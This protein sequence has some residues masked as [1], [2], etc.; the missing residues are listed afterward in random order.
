MSS[1]STATSELSASDPPSGVSFC[2]YTVPTSETQQC[3]GGAE[4]PFRRPV[5]TR[6]GDGLSGNGNVKSW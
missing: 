6:T 2:T 5:S 3:V 4:C 1:G